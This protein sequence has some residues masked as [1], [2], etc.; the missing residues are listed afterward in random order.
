MSTSIKDLICPHIDNEKA[1]EAD[2][3]YYCDYD[4]MPFDSM[5]AHCMYCPEYAILY[6]KAGELLGWRKNG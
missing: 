1:K 5:L 6:A 2:S 4:E 3:L